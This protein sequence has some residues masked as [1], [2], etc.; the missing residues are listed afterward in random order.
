MRAT[1]RPGGE[2][3]PA[4]LRITA[5]VLSITSLIPVS[6]WLFA[7]AIGSEPHV[8]LNQLIFVH[9]LFLALG[10]ATT[11]GC[12]RCT[13]KPYQPL[14]LPDVGMSRTLPGS[15]S[16]ARRAPACRS[17]KAEKAQEKDDDDDEAD[18]VNDAVH[19]PFL[20]QFLSRT[21]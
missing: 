7:P 12:A 13:L 14:P 19:V 3:I 15:R 17:P 8:C 4:A 10:E 9:F 21:T 20:C 2:R 16:K 1:P 11:G 6:S 5:L 18:D